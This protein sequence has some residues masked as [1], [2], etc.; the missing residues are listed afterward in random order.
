[1]LEGHSLNNTMMVFAPH[2]DDATLGCGG[3][4]AERVSQGCEVIIVV[5]TDGRHAFSKGLNISVEPTPE[6][7]KQ[8]RKEE[9]IIASGILG[10][11]KKNL[12]FLDFEDGTLE[13]HEK[14][15]IKRTIETIGEHSQADYYF[16]FIRDCHPDHRATNRIVRQ[17][18]RQLGLTGSYQYTIIHIFA[19]IGPWMEKFLSIFKRDRIEVDVSRFLGIK[20]RA[21]KAYKSELTVISP[22]QKE[23][24][25]TDIGW[26][27]KQKE[28]FYK[29]R[30]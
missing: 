9:C 13:K 2:P 28:V 22:K 5:M 19:R 27:L 26:F 21:L 14:E 23:P 30:R 17:A 6:E 7:V 20:E 15:V 11:P 10:V 4:I 12:F 29:L 18:L 1:M 24:L 8:M 25:H 16:P 3:I